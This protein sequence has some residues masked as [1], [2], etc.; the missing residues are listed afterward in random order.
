MGLEQVFGIN[1]RRLRKARGLTQEA[2]AH[3]VEIDVSY[4]GQIERG[5]RNPTLSVVE[6]FAA[7]L[8]ALPPDLLRPVSDFDGAE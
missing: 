1:V 3:E 5:E 2:L 8:G 7:A 4:L 6:R